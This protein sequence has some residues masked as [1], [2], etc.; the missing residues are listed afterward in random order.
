M[1]VK[2][3]NATAPTMC[4]HQI[5]HHVMKSAHLPRCRHA[6]T[7]GRPSQLSRRRLRMFPL[8]KHRHAEGRRCAS[9]RP[10]S[11]ALTTTRLLRRHP[12]LRRQNLL[13]RSPV[14]R[15]RQNRAAWAGGR[16]EADRR[17]PQKF[18]SE[19]LS[20]SLE[21]ILYVAARATT[22]PRPEMTNEKRMG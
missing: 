20:P 6:K 19:V 5:H 22:M 7:S 1:A 12:P 14:R 3:T 11:E 21:C 9:P 17:S 18:S 16:S 15:K 2:V 13:F 8:N 4:H 10:V